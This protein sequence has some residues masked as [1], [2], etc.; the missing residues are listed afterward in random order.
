MPL[1]AEDDLP[2]HAQL[3]ALLALLPAL[4][5]PEARGSFFADPPIVRRLLDAFDRH[6][7]VLAFDWP[8]WHAE[9]A[10][11][12]REPAALAS[13]PLRDLCRLITTLVR[14]DRFARGAFAEALESG[15]VA[16]IL[17][18]LQTLRDEAPK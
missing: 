11:Y 2:G 7:F 8:A 6:G 4:A 12:R 9:A 15:L 3:D 14:A 1:A 16:A 18:R 10:R 13:A 17:R 5:G